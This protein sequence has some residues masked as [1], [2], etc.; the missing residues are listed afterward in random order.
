MPGTPETED[1]KVKTVHR[2][3]Y[4]ASALIKGLRLS[5]A[6]A[7]PAVRVAP[8]REIFYCEWRM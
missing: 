6:I 3:P 2:L 5:P 7:T 8:D 4:L 1:L